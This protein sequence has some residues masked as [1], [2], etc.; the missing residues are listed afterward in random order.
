MNL[1]VQSAND[2]A[3]GQSLLDVT[4]DMFGFSSGLFL[5]KD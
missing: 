1:S 2:H 3:E 5:V 4:F